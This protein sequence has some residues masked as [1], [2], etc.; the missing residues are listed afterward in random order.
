MAAGDTIFATRSVAV[1]ATPV[2]GAS[3]AR[4]V[5]ATKFA[6]NQ[7]SAGSPGP[8]DAVITHRSLAV[9]VYGRDP[10]ALLAL[11][12]AAAA[13]VA[14]GTIGASGANETLTL[15]DVYFCEAIGNVEVSEKDAGGKV[16][17]FGIRGYV[18]FG[19]GDVFT[20]VL[21]AA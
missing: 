1:G 15:S 3:H 20:D 6:V 2:A 11:I 21:T 17:V 13:D 10:A 18:T 7:G 4:I 19:A 12:G 5:P 16:P 8:A 9:E 14:V